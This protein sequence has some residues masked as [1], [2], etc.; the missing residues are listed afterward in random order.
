MFNKIG[1]ELLEIINEFNSRK[2]TENDSSKLPQHILQTY[3][4]VTKGY[5][6]AEISNLIK[7]P[8]S[9]VS[10]QIETII[11]YYPNN[12]YDSLIPA[13]EYEEIKVNILADDENLK[14]IKKRVQSNISYA[15]I[16]IVKTILF[17]EKASLDGI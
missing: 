9:I 4:L 17:A 8:E 15:K 10:L 1:M 6:L 11:S 16:R 14:E 7:L 13:D 12:N 3:E 2:Q 5:S